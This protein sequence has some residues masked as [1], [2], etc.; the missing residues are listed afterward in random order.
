MN[1]KAKILDNISESIQKQFKDYK[2]NI[3]VKAY[4]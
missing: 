3:Y 4:S 2:N 1:N